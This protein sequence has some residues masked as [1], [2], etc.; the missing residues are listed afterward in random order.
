MKYK[1]N[2]ISECNW[3]SEG[4]GFSDAMLDYPFVTKP[5]SVIYDQVDIRRTWGR[6]PSTGLPLW[7][8]EPTTDRH[9]QEVDEE[10]IGS[11]S[12]DVVPPINNPIAA[13]LSA[14]QISADDPIDDI[15]ED[16][17]F[18]IWGLESLLDPP[19]YPDG[20][21]D[22]KMDLPV[23]ADRNA[24]FTAFMVARGTD[25]Q[26]LADYWTDNPDATYATVADDFEVF[27]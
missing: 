7:V 2:I 13:S 22:W 8:D 6:D 4:I 24:A 15:D 11:M 16:E 25:L 5:G 27:L 23:S 18:L 21:E 3:S 19:V 17:R 9:I 14:C 12:T 26:L 20:K 10:G 1:A